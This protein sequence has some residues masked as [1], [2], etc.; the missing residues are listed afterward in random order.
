MTAASSTTR[1]ACAKTPS[2]SGWSKS[3]SSESRL[4]VGPRRAPR[5]RAS[6][7]RPRRRR[8]RRRRLPV[9]PAPPRRHRCLTLVVSAPWPCRPC[10]PRQRLRGPHRRWL[11]RRRPTRL[12]A[13]ARRQAVASRARCCIEPSAR[14]ATRHRPAHSFRAIRHR[15]HRRRHHTAM[16]AAMPPSRKDASQRP[17]TPSSTCASWLPWRTPRRA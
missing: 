4:S 5:R 11:A 2:S 8:P 10:R 1:V 3:N 6:T 12:P 17:R 14:C 7:H 9:A 15:P 13:E 16:A